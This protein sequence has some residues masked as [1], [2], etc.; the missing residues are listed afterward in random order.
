MMR[1]IIFKIEATDLQNK[2]RCTKVCVQ[3]Y[4]CS[5]LAVVLNIDSISPLNCYTFA[6]NAIIFSP[7]RDSVE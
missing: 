1:E 2:R 7:G 4:C 6:P 3:K 5:Q